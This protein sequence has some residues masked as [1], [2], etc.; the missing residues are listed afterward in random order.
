MVMVAHQAIG[1]YHGIIPFRRGFEIGKKS[2]SIFVALENQL[3]FIPPGCYMIKSAWVLDSKR[4]R[5]RKTINKL[6]MKHPYQMDN[7]MSNVET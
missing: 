6:I 7:K 5:H 3:S 4:S 1:M 2:G